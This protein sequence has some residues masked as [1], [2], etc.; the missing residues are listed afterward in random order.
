VST[1]AGP[2]GAAPGRAAKNRDDLRSFVNVGVLE[3]IR[4]AAAATKIPVI[5][6]YPRGLNFQSGPARLERA[7]SCSGGASTR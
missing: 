4:E 7:I 3:E 2:P 6:K 1:P 5:P